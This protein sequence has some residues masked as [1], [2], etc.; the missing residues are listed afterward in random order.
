MAAET[1]IAQAAARFTDKIVTEV[2]PLK[3]FHIAEEYHR[4]YY[5]RNLFQPYCQINIVPKVAKL[6]AAYSAKLREL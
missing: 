5:R 2:V 1:A 6:K 4:Q 3:K